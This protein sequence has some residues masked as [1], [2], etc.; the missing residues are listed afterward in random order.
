MFLSNKKQLQDMR[1]RIADLMNENQEQQVRIDELEASLAAAYDSLALHQQSH[2]DS[3]DIQELW[4]GSANTIAEVRTHSAQFVSDL[5]AERTRLSGTSTLFSQVSGSLD[6][7]IKGLTDIQEDSQVSQTRIES[8]SEVT[9]KINEFVGFIVEIS[10]QTN[11]LALNAAIEAA[12]AGEQGRGFA[13]VADE[14]RALARRTG[15]ATDNIRELVTQ[16]NTQIGET[17]QGIAETADK[18]HEMSSNTNVIVSSV[19]EV[20]GM[21]EGMRTVI[22]QASYASFITTVM[23]DHIDWIQG[24]YQRLLHPGQPLTEAITSHKA[25]RL[26]EWYFSGEGKDNFSHLKA[27]REMDKPHALVHSCG[28]AALTA[29]KEG[30]KADVI[31]HLK[32]MEAA[33]HD[34]QRCL[35]GMLD[36]IL[37]HMAT[38]ESPSGDQEA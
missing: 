11:L 19:N 20:I 17:K 15:E 31:H 9:E 5:S 26:G 22:S 29:N 34:V 4:G 14:V 27:Y 18:S 23:M 37:E 38:R 2:H 30:N 6:S 16:I 32:A 1:L 28:V 3:Y 10:D 7:L 36:E 8:V 25:C 12:R 35:D 24:I 13:V 21:S 33:S